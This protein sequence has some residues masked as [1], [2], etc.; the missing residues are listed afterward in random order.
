LE[1]TVHETRVDGE[2]AP[3]LLALGAS[4]ELLVLGTSGAGGWWSAR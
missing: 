3:R 4:A 2:P 1:S